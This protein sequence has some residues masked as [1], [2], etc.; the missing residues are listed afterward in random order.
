MSFFSSSAVINVAHAMK[1]QFFE[2]VG[3]ICYL[4]SPRI[5]LLLKI[6]LPFI[7]NDSFILI[8]LPN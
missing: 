6:V 1:T 7:V 2:V 4:T 5:N 8:V 3:Y